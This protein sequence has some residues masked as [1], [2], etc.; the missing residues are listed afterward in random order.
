MRLVLAF[1]LAAAA[2]AACT[3][4]ARAMALR[5][6]IVNHPNPIVPQHRRPVAY[7]GGLG[8]AGGIA[9]VAAV[10]PGAAFAGVPSA[11][12]GVGGALFLAL[13]L[14][15]D[16]RPFRPG[17]K[18]ALQCA[19]ALAAAAAG[20]VCRGTGVAAL[21][22]A[23]SALW[24]V[25]MVNAVNF[26][27]VCDG[28]VAAVGLAVFVVLGVTAPELGAGAMAVA[29]ASLGVLAFNRPPASIFLGDAGAH[30]AGFLLAAATLAGMD[31]RPAWPGLAWALLAG[32]VFLFEAAFIT[33]QRVRKGLAP[34]R[35]SPDHFAL[36]LQAAGVSRGR[37]DVLAALAGSALALAGAALGWL[38]RAAGVSLLAAVL[39]SL[40]AAWRALARLDAPAGAHRPPLRAGDDR[41]VAAA[42]GA[43]R[44]VA[45]DP[46]G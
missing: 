43:G 12:I 4:M 17:T 22:V 2:G 14:V 41:P 36:R 42:E 26:T 7:L 10:D 16:V 3:W 37:V 31:Q 19:A 40:T 33:V 15:D 20:V 11:G 45:V 25:V 5:L 6:G 46:G 29:G 24:L 9:A 39:L 1:A 30:L 38:D 23:L 21:D 8:L 35:G 28:L 13:G 44:V 27:D 18:L 34:W 32:G